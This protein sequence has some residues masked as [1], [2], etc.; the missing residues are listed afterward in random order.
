MQDS[1]VNIYIYNQTKKVPTITFWD[2]TNRSITQKECIHNIVSKT[3]KKIEYK[4]MEETIMAIINNKTNNH[5]KMKSSSF[6]ETF[7]LKQVVNKFCTGLKCS[8][9]F[10]MMNLSL[11]WRRYH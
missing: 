11:E 4:Y 10:R 2:K 5:D 7:S 1:K 8:Y 9:E 6:M 3:S